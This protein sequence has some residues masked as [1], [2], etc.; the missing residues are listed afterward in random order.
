[1]VLVGGGV[2]VCFIL[3]VGEGGKMIINVDLR[4]ILQLVNHSEAMLSKNSLLWVVWF[5]FE[6]VYYWNLLSF[7]CWV[8]KEGQGFCVYKFI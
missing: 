3:Y 4:Y 8:V 6:G 7:N 1:M 5:V 2:K